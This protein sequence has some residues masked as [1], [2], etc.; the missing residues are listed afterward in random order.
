MMKISICIEREFNAVKR[1]AA[2]AHLSSTVTSYSEILVINCKFFLPLHLTPPFGV[3]DNYRVSG[4]LEKLEH[5]TNLQ[6]R[7]PDR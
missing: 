5:E 6:D 4:A 3:C 7:A 1:V 2:C